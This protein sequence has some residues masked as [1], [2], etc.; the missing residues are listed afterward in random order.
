MKK[1]LYQAAPEV[2]ILT[3]TDAASDWNVIMMT[4]LPFL[5][6]GGGGGGG[7]G[8]ILQ[9]EY[10]NCKSSVTVHFVF[11]SQIAKSIGSTL[12]WYRSDLKVSDR[13]LIDVYPM[14]FAAWVMAS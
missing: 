11:D 1:D 10:A 8:G 5:C 3:I 6:M 4:T 14:V 12:I 9:I 7:G 13:C 2:V